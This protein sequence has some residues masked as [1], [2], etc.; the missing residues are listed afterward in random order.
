MVVHYM[1]ATIQHTPRG[2]RTMPDRIAGWGWGTMETYI[3]G[4]R[5]PGCVQATLEGDRLNWD[6]GI[7]ATDLADQ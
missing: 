2:Y 3:S 4:Q 7:T 5:Y 6:D 1:E